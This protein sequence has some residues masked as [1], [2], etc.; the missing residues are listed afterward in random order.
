MGSC[1]GNLYKEDD[2]EPA[3]YG[4][5]DKVFDKLFPVNTQNILKEELDQFYTHSK[6][7]KMQ[8]HFL[9]RFGGIRDK[10]ANL[11]DY[12]FTT[13]TNIFDSILGN[14][15]SNYKTKSLPKYKE[16]DLNIL[17]LIIIFSLTYYITGGG[18][19]LIYLQNK[20]KNVSI[21]S[22]KSLLEQ[23]IDYRIE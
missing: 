1:C 21:F 16:D 3:D 9:L 7:T 10:N 8:L 5:V 13:L 2:K 4:D 12:A 23:L 18:G 11:D 15:K 22:E 20:M 6:E 14:I 19:E 17:D